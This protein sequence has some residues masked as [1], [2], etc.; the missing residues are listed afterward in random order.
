MVNDKFLKSLTAIFVFINVLVLIGGY[1]II[2]DVFTSK[3]DTKMQSQYYLK[4]EEDLLAKIDILK[5]S[6]ED[7]YSNIQV[8]RDRIVSLK[9]EIDSTSN[10]SSYDASGVADLQS[11]ISSARNLNAVLKA[12]VNS[13]QNMVAMQS[14]TT[15]TTRPM[16][17]RMT[18]SS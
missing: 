8:L 18:R 6:N 1:V 16:I 9:T 2:N 4:K 10:D 5:N 11:E 13:V 17:T 7:I 15:T 14:S 3:A 12:K